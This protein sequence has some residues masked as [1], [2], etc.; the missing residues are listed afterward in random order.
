VL[1]FSDITDEGYQIENTVEIGGRT[2]DIPIDIPVTG[3]TDVPLTVS[4]SGDTMTTKAE[5]SPFTTTWHREG[6]AID[7]G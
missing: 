4:C 2:V 7:L 3:M 6:D 1:G 5:Q